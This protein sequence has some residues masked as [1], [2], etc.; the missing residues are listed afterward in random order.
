M[1]KT[2]NIEVELYSK[3][4]M[5]DALT[6]ALDGVKSFSPGEVFEY[7]QSKFPLYPLKSK[8]HAKTAS[9]VVGI[10]SELM[11][12]GSLSKSES[13]QVNLYLK[14]LNQW[15]D[16]F[17][18]EEAEEAILV[19]P[20]A[21]KPGIADEILGNLRAAVEAEKARLFSKMKPEETVIEANYKKVRAG[22]LTKAN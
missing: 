3:P 21:K 5:T 18:A 4:E 2:E 6:G 12:E 8:A 14:T 13:T 9:S 19:Q 20:S 11:S 7:L 22:K 10:L 17:E 15:I 16:Q 1:K